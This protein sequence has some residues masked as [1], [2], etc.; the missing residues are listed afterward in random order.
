M[1]TVRSFASL[2]FKLLGTYML[3]RAVEGLSVIP[4]ALYSFPRSQ[5][6]FSIVTFKIMLLLQLVPVIAFG[7]VLIAKSN[8]F[9]QWAVSTEGQ[10][11][12]VVLTGEATQSLAFSV[13]GAAFFVFG[14]SR[15]VSVVPLFM[16]TR[17][18]QSVMFRPVM[19]FPSFWPGLTEGLAELAMGAYLFF[20]AGS[21]SKLWHRIQ[22]SR[23]PPFTREQN[24]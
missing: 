15:L 20:G 12:E 18:A 1:M 2:A 9:A 10:V 11:E 4:T 17:T 16:I 14:A 7:V 19:T 23:M 22:K 3:V 8:V 13:L 21:L 6:G 5:T 24:L